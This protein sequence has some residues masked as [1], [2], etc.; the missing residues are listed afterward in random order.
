MEWLRLFLIKLL[1]SEYHKLVIH[2]FHLKNYFSFS[3]S[4]TNMSRF[5]VNSASWDRL[6]VAWCD[7]SVTPAATRQLLL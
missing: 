1:P 7:P 3:S 6:W 2:L 4:H 5:N